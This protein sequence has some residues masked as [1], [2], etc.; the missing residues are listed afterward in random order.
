MLR[1]E[2]VTAQAVAGIAEQCGTEVHTG[3]KYWALHDGADKGIIAIAI[4]SKQDILLYF[5]VRPD[6]REQGYGRAL[7]DMLTMAHKRL[8]TAI[9][10][11]GRAEA[12][13]LGAGF[14]HVG[15]NVMRYEEV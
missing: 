5:G 12:V 2:Q 8:S 11:G 10:P 1:F 6:L 13:L 15:D 4:V 3:C 9:I 14:K 7:M